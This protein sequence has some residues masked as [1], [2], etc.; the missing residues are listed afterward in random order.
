M[1]LN[2]LPLVIIMMLLNGPLV[3]QETNWGPG[4]NTMLANNP[5]FSGIAGDGT[6]RM[7]YLNFYPGHSYNFHTFYVSYDSYFQFIHGGAGIYVAND[8]IG[9]I[10]NDL[11]G[12]LSYSYFL[13]AGE[14]LY[15]SA[16]LS[17]S[18]FNRGF[19]F[20]SA[21]LPDQIDAMGMISH[22][23]AENLANTN[24]AVLDIGTGV[25]IIFG[26]WFGG[27]SITHLAQPDISGSGSSTDRLKRKFLLNIAGDY[28]F[29]KR[30]NFRIRPAGAVELQG[31]YLSFCEGA[32]FETPFLSF[33]TAIFESNNKTLDLQAGFSLKKDKLSVFYNYRFNVKSGSSLLPFSL[34]HQAGLTLV[35]NNVEKRIKFK[36][37][38]VPQL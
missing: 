34:V 35:L 13:Q 9:G 8:Y 26:N 38:K 20:T 3:C 30:D 24:R 25:E 28:K 14:D 31:S 36:T 12:G 5:A 6:L 18:F 17:A 19:N 1:K 22:P 15:I 4:Y 7:S 21:V 11:R 37:I 10:V 32:V 29:G 23:T 16:G 2:I 27:L 33:N